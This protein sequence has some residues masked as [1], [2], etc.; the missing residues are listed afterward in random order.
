MLLISLWGF[1]RSSTPTA[2]TQE[3]GARLKGIQEMLA[4][5]WYSLASSS[6]GREVGTSC[7]K[8]GCELWLC[9]IFDSILHFSQFSDRSFRRPSKLPVLFG[10]TG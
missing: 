4:K 7:V 1:S 2:A 10:W 5:G 6:S 3:I 8:H 9:R